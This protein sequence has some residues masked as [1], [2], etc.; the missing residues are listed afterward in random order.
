MT[1]ADIGGIYGEKKLNKPRAEKGYQS[2]ARNL[3]KHL[4]GKK[5]KKG[6]N[7]YRTSYDPLGISLGAA[8]DQNP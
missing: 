3:Q 7:K 5:S 1:T 8:F 4:C 6:A 2:E